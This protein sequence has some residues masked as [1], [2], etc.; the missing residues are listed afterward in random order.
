MFHISHI[1]LR[2]YLIYKTPRRQLWISK[3]PSPNLT[4]GTGGGHRYV[5]LSIGFIGILTSIANIAVWWKIRNRKASYVLFLWLSVVDLLTIIAYIVYA[6]YFLCVA[7]PVKEYGHS[8]AM[9]YLVLISYNLYVV[10]YTSSKWITIALAIFRTIYLF[11]PSRKIVWCSVKR[12]YI[13]AISVIVAVQL[14]GIPFY[15]YYKVEE[16]TLNESDVNSQNESRKVYWLTESDI[17]TSFPAFSP[18]LLWI[19][20]IL[21]EIIPSLIL[22]VLFISFITK[23]CCCQGNNH[24]NIVENQGLLHKDRESIKLTMMLVVIA[25]LY[26]T[27]GL[28]M[29]IYAFN[30][31]IKYGSNSDLFYFMDDAYIN[32]YTDPLELINC[33]VYLFVYVFMCK[34]FQRNFVAILSRLNCMRNTTQPQVHGSIQIFNAGQVAVDDGNTYQRTMF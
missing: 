2:P 15:M 16:V 32:N 8:E 20:G 5:V 11:F 4:L 31:A 30:F 23:L 10:F 3:D 13:A 21:M 28:I 9:M 12:A 22:L 14:W 25:F 6:V 26:V 18:S 27:T 19:Y 1:P 29:G 34:P 33:S 17:L 7:K 24:R